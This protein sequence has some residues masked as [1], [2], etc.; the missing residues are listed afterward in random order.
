MP[1]PRQSFDG[2]TAARQARDVIE[3]TERVAAI[4]LL[5]LCQAADIRGSENLGRTKVIHARIRAKVP[6]V[7]HDRAMDNDIKIVTGM[8]R[9]DSLLAD[10]R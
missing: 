9:D 2:A 6:R 8:M 4:H 3:I 5:S 1:Q 7:H 10:F